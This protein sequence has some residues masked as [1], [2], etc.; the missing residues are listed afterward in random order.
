MKKNTISIIRHSGAGQEQGLLV[1]QLR[2]KSEGKGRIETFFLY[3][4]I[5][6]SYNEF[7]APSSEFQHEASDRIMEIYYCRSGRIGWNMRHGVSVYLGGGDMTVHSASCCSQSDMMFPLGYSEGIAVSVD[8]SV[9]GRECPEI[10]KDAGLDLKRFQTRYCGEKPVAIPGSPEL[11]SIFAPLFS[12]HPGQRR[13]YLKLKVQ[14]LFLYLDS[15]QFEGRE[16]SQYASEQ[17]DLIREIHDLLTEHLEKRYTIEEL[18]RRY[19]MNTTMLK[20]VFRR[21]YGLPIATYMKEYRVHEAMKLLRD[22]DE[23]VGAIAGKMGYETS[24]KFSKAFK[25]VAQ[26]LPTEYRKMHRKQVK[27]VGIA[28]KMP[29]AKR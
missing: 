26:M 25:D 4:G 9:L 19:L 3:P 5:E 12:V 8:F 14:E 17:T 11:E 23:T 28:A 1:G 18:S 24:G 10:L 15:L 2:G 27:Y 22:T 13:P 21:V 29:S 16:L 6:A 20:E 7:Q